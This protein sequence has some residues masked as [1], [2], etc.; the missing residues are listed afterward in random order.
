M[1]HDLNTYLEG[2]EEND[3]LTLTRAIQL[4]QDDRRA[5]I[6]GPISFLQRYLRIGYSQA[7]RIAHHL[8]QLGLW[9][10]CTDAESGRIA[11][12]ELSLPGPE[13]HT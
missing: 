11:I 6:H 12:T 5:V 7:L 3:R 9:R 13:F 1:Q 10:V 2:F 8:E 4:L